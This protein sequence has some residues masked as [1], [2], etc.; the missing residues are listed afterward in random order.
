MVSRLYLFLLYMQ[1]RVYKR[2]HFIFA[3]FAAS[4]VSMKTEIS[5]CLSTTSSALKCVCVYIYIYIYIS[6]HIYTYISHRYIHTHMSQCFRPRYRKNSTLNSHQV[7]QFN[8]FKIKKN[9]L[10]PDS[11]CFIFFFRVIF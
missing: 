1:K 11:Y 2:L 8:C 3:R 10:S 9:V 4:S 5:Q 7:S 6:K